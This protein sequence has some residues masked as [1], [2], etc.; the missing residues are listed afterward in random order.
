[1]GEELLGK[2][3]F[4]EEVKG[5]VAEGYFFLADIFKEN[6]AKMI[7]DR[8]A[9][10]GGWHGWRRFQ[11]Q[12]GDSATH[13]NSLDCRCHRPSPSPR[14]PGV[15]LRTPGLLCQH[16]GSPAGGGVGAG[17]HLLRVLRTTSLEKT[18]ALLDKTQS[19]QGYQQ[20][21]YKPCAIS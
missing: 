1:M 10:E 18:I 15:Y 7:A 20:S 14:L 17:G 12:Q 13:L 11:Q 2:E 16:K 8:K 9:A 6:E 21:T 5:A 3:V 19:E 4:N